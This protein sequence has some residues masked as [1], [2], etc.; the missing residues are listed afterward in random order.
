MKP[1]MPKTM[2][3]TPLSVESEREASSRSVARSQTPCDQR[4]RRPPG[5][6]RQQGGGEQDHRADEILKNAAGG[7]D[8]T[9]LLGEKRPAERRPAA[10]RDRHDEP[11]P[12]MPHRN[13][14]A[15]PGDS[16]G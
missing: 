6:R 2:L 11:R 1:K 9:D 13:E 4:Q 8:Q 15:K 7:A 14:R 5:A 12:R 3:G 16:C 10:Q